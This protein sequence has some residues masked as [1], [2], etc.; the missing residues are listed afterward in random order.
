MTTE[1]MGIAE[2]M[3][4]ESTR[5]HVKCEPGIFNLSLGSSL[6]VRVEAGNLQRYLQS[7]VECIRLMVIATVLV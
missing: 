5:S 2:L 3:W 6:R 1:G 4:E 7:L